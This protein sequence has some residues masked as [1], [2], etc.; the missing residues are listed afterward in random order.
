MDREQNFWLGEKKECGLN[1]L[2]LQGD[3]SMSF[4][5]VNEQL[6]TSLAIETP[7]DAAREILS[8]SILDLHTERPVAATVPSDAELLDILCELAEEHEESLASSASGS[9]PSASSRWTVTTP[10]LEFASSNDSV[11]D[12]PCDSDSILGSQHPSRCSGSIPASQKVAP[13]NGQQP[14]GSDGDDEADEDRETLEMS[15][16]FHLP[17]DTNEPA[18]LPRDEDSDSSDSR[19]PQLDGANDSSSSDDQPN[20]RSCDTVADSSRRRSSRRY[21]PLTFRTKAS[22]SSTPKTPSSGS[23]PTRNKPSLHT[24]PSASSLLDS[25]SMAVAST[26][27][28]CLS[29][30]SVTAPAPLST[31]VPAE[32]FR[33][34]MDSLFAMSYLS[35][36]S[37][38]LPESPPR[39]DTPV[40]KTPKVTLSPLLKEIASYEASSGRKLSLSSGRV[41]LK[42]LGEEVRS[43]QKRARRKLKLPPELLEGEVAKKR[44]LSLS[45]SVQRQDEEQIDVSDAMLSRAEDRADGGNKREAAAHTPSSIP[46]P[47][48]GSF[49]CSSAFGGMK[50]ETK[51]VSDCSSILPPAG[52]DMDNHSRDTWIPSSGSSLFRTKHSSGES[53]QHDRTLVSVASGSSGSPLPSQTEVDRHNWDRPQDLRLTDSLHSRRMS[54][55][56]EE[57][58]RSRDS[59]LPDSD[60]SMF[61][62]QRAPLRASS[63]LSCGNESSTSSQ[64]T[65]LDNSGCQTTFQLGAVYTALVEAPSRQRV[66][67]T[68][69]LYG[70]PLVDNGDPFWGDPSDQTKSKELRGKMMNIGTKLVRSLPEF[71]PTSHPVR[72]FLYIVESW[73]YVF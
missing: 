72:S 7:D 24:T 16:I 10:Q 45:S 21:K 29:R 17:G 60:P 2:Y 37:Q 12:L 11:E 44:A 30:Q 69:D 38:E 25:P 20:L 67:E 22:G 9:Q 39:P 34:Y 32:E 70:I 33:E 36:R 73:F 1:V 8:A 53:G 59:W 19:L 48:E 51:D 56:E 63:S 58:A 13:T 65:L 4:V 50:E 57:E 26:A 68:M 42:S 47:N 28:L 71:G 15:Q 31:H 55:G 41:V 14:E 54:V 46:L 49:I 5:E 23:I 3:L 40:N 52:C 18:F 62:T 43:Y 35:P 64:K 66:L 6:E 27:G 61:V